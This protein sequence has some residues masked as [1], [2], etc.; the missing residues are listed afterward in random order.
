MD[1]YYRLLRAEVYSSIQKGI[2]DLKSNKL[3]DRDMYTYQNVCLAGYCV[4]KSSVCLALKFNTKRKVT[5]WAAS[6]QLMFGNLVI[7]CKGFFA[8][9]Y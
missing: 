8:L 6:R 3:D 5:N 9:F 1:T 4:Q 7:S 2:H